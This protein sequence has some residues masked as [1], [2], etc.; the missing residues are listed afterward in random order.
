MGLAS[1]SSDQHARLLFLE[2][3][4]EWQYQCVLLPGGRWEYA[5]QLKPQ[6]LPAPAVWLDVC[7][8]L[9]LRVLE[10]GDA[11]LAERR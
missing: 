11:I 10:V 7:H 2:A 9:P 6:G 4:Y 5:M 3:Q 8:E 1:L